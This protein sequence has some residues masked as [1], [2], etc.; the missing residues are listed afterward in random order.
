M[1]FSPAQQVICDIHMPGMDG[2]QLLTEMKQLERAKDIPVVSTCT[3]Q[4]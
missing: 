3:V 1:S 2:V 4:Y